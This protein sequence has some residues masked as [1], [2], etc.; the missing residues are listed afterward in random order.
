MGC[1]N[2]TILIVTSAQ[3]VNVRVGVAAGQGGASEPVHCLHLA[4]HIVAVNFFV[5]CNVSISP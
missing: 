4:T 3:G 1:D 2:V 5:L